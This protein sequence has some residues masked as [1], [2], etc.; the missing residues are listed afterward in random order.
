MG[1]D[2]ENN[3]LA[4]NEKALY[5]GDDGQDRLSCMVL[6]PLAEIRVGMFMSVVIRRSQLMV[7]A[8][9]RCKGHERQQHQNE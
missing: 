3:V 5:G 4:W 8:Q 1:G 7:Y 9:C 6:N 2:G